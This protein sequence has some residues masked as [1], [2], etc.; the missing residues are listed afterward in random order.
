MGGPMYVKE[1]QD[2]QSVR[3]GVDFI[4]KMKPSMVCV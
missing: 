1:K 3:F 4:I 2:V